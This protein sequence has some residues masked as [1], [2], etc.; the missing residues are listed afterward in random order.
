MIYLGA[1]HNGYWLKEELKTY[2][3]AR[4][5]MFKD[6]GALLL[7]KDDDY[8]DYAAKV[9]KSMRSTDLGI[10]ICG[11]GHGMAISANKIKG[12]RAANAASIFSARKAREDDHANV[13]A[14]SGWELSAERAKRIVATFLST[15]PL[16]GKRYLRRLKKVNRLEK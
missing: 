5:I 1:D 2:L 3:K 10:L 8:P 9:A 13:L 15:R 4:K 11:T 12:I 16:Q 7:H 6:M 14:L